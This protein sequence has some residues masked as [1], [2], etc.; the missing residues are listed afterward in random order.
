MA[1]AE[2]RLQTANGLLQAD[3]WLRAALP[4]KLFGELLAGSAE[5]SGGLFF[6]QRDKDEMH[7]GVGPG[8]EGALHILSIVGEK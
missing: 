6:T 4:I 2:E 7:A 3:A 8:T 1:E 5:F